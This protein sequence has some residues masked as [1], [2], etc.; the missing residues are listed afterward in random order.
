[1]LKKV[2]ATVVVFS[3]VPVAEH[4]SVSIIQVLF[5]KLC[6]LCKLQGYRVRPSCDELTCTY[7]SI[8]SF[9]LTSVNSLVELSR[10]KPIDQDS[11]VKKYKIDGY[12]FNIL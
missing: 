1:M 12:K 9:Q 6:K 5:L 10:L 11:P 7:P 3:F 4:F 8:Q 2:T